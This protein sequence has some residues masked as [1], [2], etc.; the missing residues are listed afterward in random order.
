LGSVIAA[1]NE[2]VAQAERAARAKAKIKSPS[3][4]FAA[5][6][7][8][9]IPQGVAM[10][11]AKEMP[12][13]VQ[14]M[15]KTFANGFSDVTSL[16][17]D[18]ASGMASAVADAVNTVGT[19]LDDSLA[20]MDYRPTITPVVDTT[21]LDK[22]QNGNILRGIGVDATN[23]PR[24]AYSGVPSSLQSTN[25]NVYDNSNKEYSITVKVDN[26]GKPVD[27][28]Q[29]ARE[30]QQHIKDFDDQA[31]RGKGEEVLW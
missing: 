27:G 4:L 11:I 8:K 30:I 9:Y 1:T 21:N 6:V 25:T 10:G 3:R 28:K 17:V 2:I 7:G 22:L 23:V 16:A 18:H 24:P 19:L 20:D 31:R 15:G 14:K 26:G 12:K 13:S 29:L 5:N